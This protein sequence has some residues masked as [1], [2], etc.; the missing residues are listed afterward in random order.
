MSSVGKNV[1]ALCTKCGMVLAHIILYEVRGVIAQVKCKTCGAEHK[2]RGSKPRTKSSEI[3]KERTR[4]VGTKA[5]EESRQAEAAET[6]RWL[7]RQRELREN[8]AIADYHMAGRYQRG[9]VI[10][11]PSFGIGF[12]EKILE[13]Q[14]MDVLFKGNLRRMVMN[15][16]VPAPAMAKA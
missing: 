13:E 11:H 16:N 2:Y 15:Y 4:R 1:D 6:Q 9:D 7:Q 8:A 10:N 5:D 3:G 12:V 14:R